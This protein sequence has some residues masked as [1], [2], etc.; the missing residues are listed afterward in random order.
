MKRSTVWLAAGVF[1]IVF[2]VFANCLTFDFV[3]DDEHVV[4]RN[5]YLTSVRYL[6]QLLTQNIDAGAGVHSQLY[7]PVPLLTH[8]LDVHL[9]GY[10]PWGHHLTNLLIHASATTA[11]FLWL[12]RVAPLPA[13]FCGAV[14]WGIHPVQVEG[15]AYIGGR[16]DS[17]AVLFLCS[18]LLLADRR[19]WPAAICAILAIGSKESMVL[20]PAFLWLADAARG[21]REPWRRY[22]PFWII[23]GAYILLRGTVLK[24][25]NMLNF[26]EADNILVHHPGYRVFTYLTTLTGGLRL[27]IWPWDL[28]HERGWPISTSL[29]QPPVAWSAVALVGWLALMRWGWRRHRPIAAAL[30]WYLLATLPSSNLLVLINAVFYDHWVVIPGVGLAWLV[31]QLPVFRNRFTTWTIAAAAALALVCAWITRQYT[32]AWKNALALNTYLL[33]FEPNNAKLLNNLAM[34]LA[35]TGQLEESARLYR[36]AIQASD[37]YPHTHHNLARIYEAQG[38][39]DAAAQ[40]FRRAIALNPTFHHSYIAL[41]QLEAGRGHAADAEGLFRQAIQAYPYATDAYL[42]LARLKA[43]RGDRDGAIAELRRGL[44]AVNDLRLRQA[45]NALQA[46]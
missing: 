24:F 12:T 23:A 8:F 33:K 2:L 42:G 14:L 31:S 30:T 1:L 41:G 6:P 43:A 46:D 9:W 17:L 19:F 38:N 10:H 20:F 37:T 22:L 21:R 5:I 4:L 45:L 15:V 32:P 39:L 18:G 34:A 28:H 26:Y 7:R 25:G 13:A 36:Q 11:C 29:L 44:R 3:W 40:E 16:S 35:G 27:W